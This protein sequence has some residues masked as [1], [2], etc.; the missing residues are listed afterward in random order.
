VPSGAPATD[1]LPSIIHT[2][3][4]VGVGGGR[5]YPCWKEALVRRP[6]NLLS[7]ALIVS[8]LLFLTACPFKVGGAG[9]S[10]PSQGPDGEPIVHHFGGG[11]WVHHQKPIKISLPKPPHAS[12]SDRPL[13]GSFE[14]HYPTAGSRRTAPW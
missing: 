14:E 3:I 8:A 6:N 10:D 5:T 1:S 4:V 13:A 9:S 11:G 7:L 12:R 2:L